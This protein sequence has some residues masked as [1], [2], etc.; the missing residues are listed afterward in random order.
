MTDPANAILDAE[1]IAFDKRK[2]II[3]SGDFVAGFVPPDYAIDGVVQRKFVYSMTAPT[4]GGKTAVALLLAAYKATG[5]RL[6][7]CEIPQGRVL[8][9]AGE[10]PDD[11]RM[12]WIAMG[13]SI[14]FDPATIDVHFIAG[15]LTISESLEAVSREVDRLG[16]MNL[17]IVDTSAAY[18]EGDSENDNVQM[19]E[20][21]RMLR[22]LTALPGGPCV[23]AACHPVKNA[24]NDNLLPRGGGAF[25]NEMD[26]NLVCRKKDQ[27]VDLHWQ[28][29]FRGPDFEPISFELSTG[30]S[31]LLKDSRGRSIPSVMAKPLSEKKRSELEGAARHDEDAILTVMK[32]SFGGSIASMAE[33]L[34]WKTSTGKPQKSRAHRALMKL[35]EDNLTTKHR[36]KW[37]LTKTGKMEAGKV[38]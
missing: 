6:G 11:I 26:G 25:L 32:E 37:V 34:G 20:H 2:L 17:A 38:A 9:L 10:N 4:G 36:G 13:E 7:D 29:K 24:N 8:Y 5:T 33:T 16:G 1:V 21:A 14:G 18:F 3:S 23:I 15:R 12:R 19:L 30:T 22:T 27:I 35:K 31:D 28:G